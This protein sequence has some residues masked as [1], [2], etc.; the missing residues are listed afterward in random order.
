LCECEQTFCDL[1]RL[2]VSRESKGS[3]YMVKGGK[4]GGNVLACSDSGQG[5]VVIMDTFSLSHLLFTPLADNSLW[6]PSNRV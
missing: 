4:G 2:N 6:L 1:C 3:C 5:K